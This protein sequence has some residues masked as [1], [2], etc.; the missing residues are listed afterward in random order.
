MTE[1]PMTTTAGPSQ[2]NVAP[3]RYPVRYRL[4]KVLDIGYVSLL[5]C[6]MALVIGIP[7]NCVV[8][9]FNARVVE[10]Q[11][12]V[13]LF[14]EVILQFWLVYTINYAARKT[15]ENI[16]SPFDGYYG[17]E[18]RLLKDLSSA[19]MFSVPLPSVRFRGRHALSHTRGT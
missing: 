9:P 14:F 1:G 6:V 3:H 4:F 18:H 11:S 17:F 2:P 12:T 10:R 16:P 7:L 5:Y 8:P 19:T 15:I 13:S